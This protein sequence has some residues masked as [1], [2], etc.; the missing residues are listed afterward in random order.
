VHDFPFAPTRRDAS[1]RVARILGAALLCIAI[2]AQSHRAS[3][4]PSMKPQEMIVIDAHEDILLRL[5]DPEDGRALD[6]QSWIG[7]VNFGSWRQGGINAVFFAVWMSPEQYKKE[8]AVERAH[9][10]IDCLD[11]QVSRFPDRLAKCDAADEVRQA[12]ASG[13]VAAML[14]IEGG[15]AINDTIGNIEIFRDRG[16]RYMTLTWRGNLK[17]AGSSQNSSPAAWGR[18]ARR[19]RPAVADEQLSTGGLTALGRE[20]VLEMNRV[21]MVVDLSHVSDQTFF[22]AISVTQKPVMISHSNCRALSPHPRNVTDDMLRALASNGGVMGINFW[23]D[24]LE[25]NA[26]SRDDEGATSVTLEHV[27]NH[28]D[29]VVKVAG[30]DHVGIG[31]DFEGMSSL[32]LGLENASKMPVVFEGMR[33][34][35]YSEQDIIKFAG[36]NFLRVLQANETAGD[37]QLN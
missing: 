28:I 1:A 34:R 7:H 4:N 6:E 11:S 13:K 21:G 29:H 31:T 17:W 23:S 2:A 32:P 14:G 24:L 3:G 37:R 22:D 9:A 33:R 15:V 19:G 12:V 36:E 25:P 26:K 5:L 8:K 27:L 20:I 10:M 18:L 30:I 35:G 16:V